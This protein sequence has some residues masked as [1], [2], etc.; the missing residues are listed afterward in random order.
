MENKSIRPIPLSH[1]FN[2]RGE[3]LLQ[4]MHCGFFHLKGLIVSFYLFNPSQTFQPPPYKHYSRYIDI[5]SSPTILS[6]VPPSFLLFM[7][8]KIQQRMNN[9]LLSR[10]LHRL[11][12]DIFKEAHGRLWLW[13]NEQ[14][15]ICI[16]EIW[17]PSRPAFSFFTHFDSGV[18]GFLR[19]TAACF[20]DPLPG[21]CWMDETGCL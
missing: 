17:Q 8:N 10:C 14:R 6:V 7:Y 20:D 15:I 4:A 5:S 11:T 1:T 18:C 16:T 9:L 13:V 3:L 2:L 21:W 12:Q 19:A